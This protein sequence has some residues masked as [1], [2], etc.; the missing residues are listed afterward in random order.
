M[1]RLRKLI[2]DCVDRLG[3]PLERQG[4]ASAGLIQLKT[5]TSCLEKITPK[6]MRTRTKIEAFE[7]AV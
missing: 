6:T 4:D 2:P 3:K 7:L 5:I 1:A